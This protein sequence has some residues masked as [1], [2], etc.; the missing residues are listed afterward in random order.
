MSDSQKIMVTKTF[1]PDVEE[2][3]EYVRDIFGRCQLTN[4]GPI[5]TMLEDKLQKYLG[6]LHLQYVC[7][8][9]LALQ[10]A[11]RALGLEG[12]EII[13]TPFSYVA[14]LSSILWEG[15]SPVFVDIEPEHFTI[16]PDAIE[17]AIT[18]KTKAIMPVHVFGYC[19]QVEKIDAIAKKYNLK[20]IYDGAHAFGTCYKG[21]S[22]LN[23]GDISTLSF[24]ATKLFHTI[25]GGGCI[26]GDASLNAKLDLLKK[27]G[28]R[29]DNHFT[30]G[31]NAK[32][33]EFH[34]AMGMCNLKHI[35]TIFAKRKTIC[36]L[37]NNALKG[38][39]RLPAEQ[40]NCQW[41][42]AYFPVL[43]DSKEHREYVFSQL[44][45][46]NIFPR[47]YFFPSLNTLPYVSYTPCIFSEDISDRIACLPLYPDLEEE[48]VK[49]ICN[50]ICDK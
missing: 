34:A 43:F 19:C 47:R 2:Y 7:N 12:S 28:H 41:N 33:S 21:T 31:I 15:C 46:K 35:E 37:Y 5:V 10:L 18:P 4:Q 44:A 9:T 3:I 17:A 42:Y 1:L 49:E 16:D 23:Y 11:I 40:V 32:Q 29:G 30:L 45:N 13:T 39:L 22:I 38:F 50:V 20:V 36:S 26:C 8:G 6:V 25:E 14:T 48:S 27:F 24:H